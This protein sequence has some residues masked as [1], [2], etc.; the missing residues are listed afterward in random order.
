[1]MRASTYAA[2]LMEEP[3]AALS[4]LPSL[5]MHAAFFVTRDWHVACCPL[6]LPGAA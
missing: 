6:P 1:M 5:R 4:A 2:G 3:H